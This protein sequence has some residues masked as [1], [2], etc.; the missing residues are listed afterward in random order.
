MFEIFLTLHISHCEIIVLKFSILRGIKNYKFSSILKKLRSK[1]HFFFFRLYLYCGRMSIS[2]ARVDPNFLARLHACTRETRSR[3]STKNFY[4]PPGIFIRRH[5]LLCVRYFLFR[6][7]PFFSP[8]RATLT[9]FL[10]RGKIKYR[11][12]RGYSPA[13]IRVERLTRYL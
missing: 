7:T 6:D 12:R 3:L 10:D 9:A 4:Y 5:A 1:S 2:I 13:A 8:T 11:R